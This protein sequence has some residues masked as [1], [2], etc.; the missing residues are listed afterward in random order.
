M[1][2]VPAAQWPSIAATIGTTPL[3]ATCSRNSAPAPAN[4]E[5]LVDWMRAPA[6][7]SSHTIGMRWRSACARMRRDLVLA[8]RA[9]RP[10]HHR[11]VVRRDR[12]RPAVDLADAGDRA[13]GR[14]VAVAEA[15]V[16]V[17]GEQPVL[18]PRA[19]V[20]Q[21][22]E[23]LAHRAACRASAAARRSS[24]PPIS[25][26]RVLARSRGRR[27][28]APSR[29]RRR[30]ASSR[31]LAVSGPSTRG[32]RFS[33]NAATPSAA[34]SVCVVTVSIA[35]RYASAASASISSTR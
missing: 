31:R 20:E 18:D 15:G 11:E 34:S 21:Q 29:A 1:Y 25:S 23:P 16:H 4:V 2:A 9:H 32:A 26:A 3:I 13:V 22:V 35:W 8:D 28:A 30:H 5:P 19:R 6:E 10:G 27:R 14:E 24:A 12:D 7:S 33:A 17:V